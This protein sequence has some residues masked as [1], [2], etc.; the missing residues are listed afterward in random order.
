MNKYTRK[1]RKIVNNLIK[2][3]FPRLSNKKIKLKIKKIK[4][5]SMRADGYITKIFRIT[6]DPIKY[7]NATDEQISGAIVHEL[8]H[9]EDYLDMNLIDSL[10]LFVKYHFHKKFTEKFEKQT[11]IKTIKKLSNNTHLLVNMF[12]FP[13]WYLKRCGCYIPITLKAKRQYMAYTSIPGP[14]LISLMRLYD[15]IN[16][17][18]RKRKEKFSVS[19]GL[20]GEGILNTE[21][22][23]KNTNDLKK[24]LEMVKRLKINDVCIYS[25]DAISKKNKSWLKVIKKYS[26]FPK[27]L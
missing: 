4:K 14:K 23:Y 9:F 15:K 12:P 22:V 18:L 16:F 24:D 6:I 27:Q 10:L 13:K 5:G 17:G 20:I 11:D 8:V 19:I 26:T 1:Y 2:K 7:K 25:I 3:G 21:G